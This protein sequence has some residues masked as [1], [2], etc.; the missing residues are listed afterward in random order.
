M[1]E[2]DLSG[3]SQNELTDLLEEVMTRLRQ[4][5]AEEIKKEFVT[6]SQRLRLESAQEHLMISRLVSTQHATV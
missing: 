2:I 3:M 1:N 6:K 5:D 4:I